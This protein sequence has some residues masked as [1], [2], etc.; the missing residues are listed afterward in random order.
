MYNYLKICVQRRIVDRDETYKKNE[1]KE[2]TVRDKSNSK[3][4]FYLSHVMN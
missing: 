1:N 3:A 2:D 4:Y